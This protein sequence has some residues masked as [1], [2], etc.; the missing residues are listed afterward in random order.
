[1]IATTGGG[2]D[3]GR[4]IGKE[5]QGGPGETETTTDATDLDPATGHLAAHEVLV[6]E[7]T[8]TTTIR[9][10]QG[11]MTVEAERAMVAISTEKVSL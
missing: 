3:L 5:T 9:D 10:V 1:M 11:T 7:A 2:T 8:V 6:M 4:E